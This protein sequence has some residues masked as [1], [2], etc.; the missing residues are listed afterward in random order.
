MAVARRQAFALAKDDGD[1]VSAD[2]RG[3]ADALI[4]Q[5]LQLRLSVVHWLRT[6]AGLQDRRLQ[7]Q[8]CGVV[9]RGAK[10]VLKGEIAPSLFGRSKVALRRLSGV[11]L[12]LKGGLGLSNRRLISERRSQGLARRL[13]RFNGVKVG[14]FGQFGAPGQRKI[15]LRIAVWIAP[16]SASATLARACVWVY[17]WVRNKGKPCS[18]DLIGFPAITGGCYHRS[19]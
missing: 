8:A 16:S 9:W 19:T 2:R 15:P 7:R 6:L 13:C 11:D 5:V 14:G 1:L 12:R 4:V 18:V 3:E 10:A 17:T